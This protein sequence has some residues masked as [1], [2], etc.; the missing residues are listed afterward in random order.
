MSNRDIEIFLWCIGATHWKW[1]PYFI[2]INL[3]KNVI[4]KT[5]LSFIYE[6]VQKSFKAWL[7]YDWYPVCWTFSKP[8]HCNKD[9]QRRVSP[10]SNVILVRIIN[11]YNDNK[12]KSNVL[13]MY[14]GIKFTWIANF[15][16]IKTCIPIH[17][18]SLTNLFKDN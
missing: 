5:C 1:P 13:P 6:I 3:L 7:S 11:K 10:A 16:N 17:Y 15:N 18:I 12:K 2:K 4:S 9:I 8:L 14:V